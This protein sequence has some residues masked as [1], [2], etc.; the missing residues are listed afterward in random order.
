[1]EPLMDIDI[2][3]DEAGDLMRAPGVETVSDLLHSDRLKS[4]LK[5]IKLSQSKYA[6]NALGYTRELKI[7]DYQ[8]INQSNL[9]VLEIDN[10]LLRIWKFI[11]DIYATKFPEL[12][13]MVM[14]PI[15][16]AKCVKLIGNKT[17]EEMSD[18]DL[19]RVLVGDSMPNL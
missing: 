10:H 4:H 7:A 18:L 1:M 8:L 14:N 9:L 5:A 6:N 17:P 15:E 3:E 12:E 13:E 16:Y 19:R 2:M 11:R